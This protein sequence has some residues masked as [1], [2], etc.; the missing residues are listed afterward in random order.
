M[1][2]KGNNSLFTKVINSPTDQVYP[3]GIT[4]EELKKNGFRYQGLQIAQFQQHLLPIISRHL[5]SEGLGDIA[6]GRLPKHLMNKPVK[7]GTLAE[8]KENRESYDRAHQ[9]YSKLIRDYEKDRVEYRMKLLKV[10]SIFFSICPV[11]LED[12]VMEEG[13][14][15]TVDQCYGI[16]E[17]YLNG[18][19]NIGHGIQWQSFVVKI[20]TERLRRF[21]SNSF[22]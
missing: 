19:N 7:P 5:V 12:K 16:L 4:Y 9:N 3:P 14:P 2:T 21:P 18:G 17:E 10:K 20:H 11:R 22:S 15:L 1:S 13:K 6:K 8:Y